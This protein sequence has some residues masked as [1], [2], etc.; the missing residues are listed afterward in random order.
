V[1]FIKSVPI[2]NI[3]LDDYSLDGIFFT[4]NTTSFYIDLKYEFPFLTGA[5]AAY[6][7]DI[8][9]FGEGP[10]GNGGR[11]EWDQEVI[12]NALSFGYR[13]NSFWELKLSLADQNVKG[14]DWD[15]STFRLM[16]SF[17]W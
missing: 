5:Y 14:R 10:D 12:R 2:F 1:T 16:T 11:T 17:F 9:S 7:F 15:Q 4:L 13:I 8:L 6:R 3:L